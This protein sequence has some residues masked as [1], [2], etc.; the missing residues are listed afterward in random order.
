MQRFSLLVGSL[1]FVAILAQPATTDAGCYCS[2]CYCCCC[3]R[4]DPCRGSAIRS[5]LESPDPCDSP[6][7][8][9]FVVRPYYPGYLWHD[10]V[11]PSYFKTS[12]SVTGPGFGPVGMGSR[13]APYGQGNFGSFTGANQ[14][15][16]HLL[17]LGGF[18][19]AGG[20]S[21]PNRGSSG[22]IIDR[23]QAR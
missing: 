9:K 13:P 1:I 18:G 16:S 15:E 5:P 7:G 22:D 14:D 20:S 4:A 17:H 11:P 12:Y 10:C 6:V 8:G 19:P 21:Q 23:L 3:R 2:G